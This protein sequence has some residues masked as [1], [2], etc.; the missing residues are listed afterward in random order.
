MQVAM[1]DWTVHDQSRGGQSENRRG[2]EKAT[3]GGVGERDWVVRRQTREICVCE[4]LRLTSVDSERIWRHLEK[5]V[6]RYNPQGAITS[7]VMIYYQGSGFDRFSQNY[8]QHVAGIAPAGWT[9]SVSEHWQNTE[10]V[11]VKAFLARAS[12]NGTDV[13]QDHLLINLGPA[14]SVGVA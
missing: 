9:L 7:V 11:A 10:S 3:T 5:L 4:A 6:D 14:E 12:K 13:Y 8:K 1:L 2:M